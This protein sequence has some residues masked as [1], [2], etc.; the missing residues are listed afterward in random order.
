MRID[1]LEPIL[2]FA[3]SS[4]AESF[5]VLI[6]FGDIL[7]ERS[8]LTLRE[9]AN[10]SKWEEVVFIS[11]EDIKGKDSQGNLIDRRWRERN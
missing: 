1:K 7:P 2:C 11:I 10:L 4:G 5:P 9:I 3:M 8:R 6:D